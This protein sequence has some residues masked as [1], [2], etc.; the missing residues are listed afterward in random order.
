MK[1][2]D[3]KNEKIQEIKEKY[4]DFV[5]ENAISFLEETIKEY[6]KKEYFIDDVK[7][8]ELWKTLK[9]DFKDEIIKKIFE[10]V[11]EWEI[12]TTSPY[13]TSLYNKDNITWGSK[14]ENSL[15]ISDHWNFIT[16]GQKHCKME[17]ESKN[18]HLM[19]CIYQNGIYKIIE[20]LTEKFGEVYVEF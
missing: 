3:W 8:Y 15:R 6:T 1:L 10:I 17:N 14:P 18:N 2:N 9:K 12:L 20:D 5:G 19:L 11:K 13:S 4:E 7:F 16:H